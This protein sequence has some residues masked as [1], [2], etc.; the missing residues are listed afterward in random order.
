MRTLPIKLTQPAAVRPQLV[1]NAALQARIMLW[2]ANRSL[3]LAQCARAPPAAGAAPAPAAAAAPEGPA[4]VNAAADSG[5]CEPPCGAAPAAGGEAGEGASGC[6]ARRSASADPDAA[7]CMGREG[8]GR[9]GGLPPMSG[10]GGGSEG[11]TGSGPHDGAPGM[12]GRLMRVFNNAAYAWR[13]APRRRGGGDAPGGAVAY[14]N[15]TYLDPAPR[16]RSATGGARAR[17]ARTHSASAGAGASLSWLLPPRQRP[18]SAGKPPPGAAG[19]KIELSARP[20]P[21]QRLRA[22]QGAAEAPAQ[23]PGEGLAGA[24]AMP[25]AAAGICEDLFATARSDPGPET[26]RE[27]EPGG[28]PASAHPMP[29]GAGRASWRAIGEALDAQAQGC[30][31]DGPAGLSI[32]PGAIPVGPADGE[33]VASRADSGSALHTARSSLHEDGS[34]RAGEPADGCSGS[35][36]A[37][38]PN[39]NLNPNPWHPGARAPGAGRLRGA[40]GAGGCLGL[41]PSLLPGLLPG[42]LCGG[43]GRHIAPEDAGSDEEWSPD[44]AREA[45]A[46]ITYICDG[47]QTAGIRD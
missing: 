26:A 42:R 7:S 16:R 39:L 18:A 41:L 1:A 29:P 19:P 8:S 35:A 40:P 23:S 32:G 44:S 17:A 15:P 30:T 3:D 20:A 37:G 43:V 2:T 24:P 22:G 14:P 25:A 9:G 45:S 13:E 31:P 21:V 12:G 36:P 33:R 6:S 34:A 47:G 4:P 46:D 10:R 27:R 38:L 5:T 11:L 28:H